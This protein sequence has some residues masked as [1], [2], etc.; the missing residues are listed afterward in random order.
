MTEAARR[1]RLAVYDLS[2][3]ETQL[4][5]D[6]GTVHFVY[7]K[8][9]AARFDRDGHSV[10]L[11]ADEGAF[12]N[13]HVIVAPGSEVWLFEKAP[14]AAPY[15]PAEPVAAHP[16]T[17]GFAGPVLVRVDRIESRHGAQTPRHGHR[18]PGMRRLV[19]GTL[20]ADVGEA[21]HRI[22]AG[23]A[24]FETGTEP[25][26]G[27][28]YGGANAAFVRMLAL[29]AELEGGKSSFIAADAGEAAKP[30]SVDPRLFGE[31]LEAE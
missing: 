18:G 16:A 25:V 5:N 4:P 1:I 2:E 13:G 27:T 12:A 3:G 19:F 31:V 23:D 7:V 10:G 14:V 8:T 6:A 20:R 9:G 26:V 11:G 29:P 30:R 15:A 17:L 21:V 24:W 28:N 22:R